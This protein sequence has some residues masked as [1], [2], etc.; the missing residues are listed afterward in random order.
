MVWWYSLLYKGF[1]YKGFN[2]NNIVIETLVLNRKKMKIKNEK[3]SLK[4]LN[5]ES[6]KH[7]TKNKHHGKKHHKTHSS[8][9]SI[10]VPL[11]IRFK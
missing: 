2:D 11:V 8:T 7:K 1:G 5:H 4:Q 10:L 6:Y 9:I 3:N